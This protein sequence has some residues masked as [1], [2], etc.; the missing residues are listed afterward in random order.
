MKKT[1]EDTDTKKLKGYSTNEKILIYAR[2][3]STNLSV[4]IAE[5]FM[6]ANEIRDSKVYKMLRART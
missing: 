1:I 4:S 6:I 3:Y 5:W 2:G